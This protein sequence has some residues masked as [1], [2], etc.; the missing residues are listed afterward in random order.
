MRQSA[1]FTELFFRV[2]PKVSR[3]FIAERRFIISNSVLTTLTKD[4]AFICFGSE[5]FTKNAG[6][7]KDKVTETAEQLLNHGLILALRK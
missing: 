1:L 6:R 3:A 2:L 7:G 4:S 5:L